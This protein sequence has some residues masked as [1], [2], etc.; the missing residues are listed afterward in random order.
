MNRRDVVVVGLLTVALAL[1]GARVLAPPSPESRHLSVEAIEIPDAPIASGQTRRDH[2]NWSPPDDVFVVGWLPGI[3]APESRPSLHLLK[4]ETAVFEIVRAT[5]AS[6]SPV[7]FPSG[8]GF[9]VRRGETLTL[10][11]QVSNSGA[12]GTTKGARVLV[13][14]HPVVWR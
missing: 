2:A 12:A 7:F 9:L 1:L 6:A 4:G 13:Y 10:R 14:F 11:L 8:T 5:E 3:G